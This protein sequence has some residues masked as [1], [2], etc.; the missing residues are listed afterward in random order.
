MQSSDTNTKVV[1]GKP[2]RILEVKRCIAIHST[3]IPLPDLWGCVLFDIGSS[4]RNCLTFHPVTS[5]VSWGVSCTLAASA[6]AFLPARAL[7]DLFNTG[8]DAVESGIPLA[9]VGGDVACLRNERE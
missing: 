6:L 1:R 4:E 3:S 2:L 7:A 8:T 5:S 9:C